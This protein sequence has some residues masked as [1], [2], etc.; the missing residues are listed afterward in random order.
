MTAINTNTAS[1][2]A[3]YFLAKANKEMESSMAK[4][5][6][7]QKVN[8]AADDAAG[9]AIAGRMTSQIKG[10]NMAIKNANDTVALAQ[11]AESAME[12]VTNML[13]R[14]R[15]LAVQ[16][17]NGTMNDRDRASLDSEVQAL[18]SE[19]DR[20]SGTTQFNNQNLLDGSFSKTFQI[21]DKTGQTVD[22]AIDSVS[23]KSLGLGATVGATSITGT[24]IGG[25]TAGAIGTTIAA[26]DIKINGQAVGAIDTSDDMEA[27]L[28]AIN[29]NVDNVVATAHNTVVAK[30]KGDGVV[31]NDEFTIA[32]T[33]YGASTATTF[34]ISA[35]GSMKELVANINRETGGVVAASI[36]DE[37]KLVLSNTSGVGITVD[38]NSASGATTFDGG[39]GFQGQTADLHKGFIT[40]SSTDGS[41]VRVEKGNL[42]NSSPGTDAMLAALGFREVTSESTNDK[43]TV[44]GAA[45][46]DI[47][48]AWGTNDVMINDVAI[49]DSS[50]NT[51]TVKGRVDAINHFSSETGVVASLYY[52]ALVDVTSMFDHT[53]TAGTN[54]SANQMSSG[55]LIMINGF[56]DSTMAVGTSASAMVTN[57]NAHTDDHGITASLQGTANLVLTGTNMSAVNIEVVQVTTL[58]DDGDSGNT[59]EAILQGATSNVRLRLDSVNDTPIRIELSEDAVTSVAEH[60]FL[61]ANIGAADYDVNAPMMNAD[62][63]GNVRGLSIATTTTAASALTSIDKAIDMINGSRSDLGALQNRLDHT[64]NNLSSVTNA[65]EGARGRIIDTDFASETAKLAKQQI[66]SQ[67]ATSMLAQANQSKQGILALLQG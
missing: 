12:E 22:L 49:Y 7:G 27:V 60:G 48:T 35:S 44:T 37:G 36:N 52:E 9:L 41:A 63:V 31:G 42:G 62:G 17:S 26:G 65:T 19:I 39:T 51:D 61:E 59:A 20:V 15:E 58:A 29:D 57:I 1:L 67:A 45:M 43:Y 30:V 40:L 5:S 38:D 18:K 13:Q 34:T 16:A 23:T 10:L 6:S 8:S 56:S 55:D 46:S 28:K 32:V 4:L 53:M 3:Q 33:E 47:T 24:R 25:S 21:G 2:N 50:I 14:M 66:L 54:G 11:T 64:V